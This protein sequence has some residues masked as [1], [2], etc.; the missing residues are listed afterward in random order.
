ME[1]IWF[2]IPAY[3]EEENLRGLVSDWEGVISR[4]KKEADVKVFIVND[5]SRDNTEGVLEELCEKYDFLSYETKENGG[6]GSAL[7]YGYGRAIAKGADWIFQTDSDRQTDPG[8][9]W[10]FWKKRSGYD[11]LIGSRHGRKDG[12]SRKFVEKTLCII[13]KGIFGVGLPDANAPFRLMKAGLVSKY[14]ERMPKDYNLPNVMLT[15]FFAY[16]R[17]NIRFIAISFG[18]RAGGENSIDIVKI[19]KIGIGAVRDFAGFRR[20]MK[21]QSSWMV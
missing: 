8:E 16:Y 17:E 21:G 12:E 11:A 1:K 20:Q 10:K 14:M 4:L 19:T 9:F 2:V 5:G 3:N 15:T 7:L 18:K 6:H 13:L